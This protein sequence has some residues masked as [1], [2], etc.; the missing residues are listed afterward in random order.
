LLYPLS[1]GGKRLVL[2]RKMAAAEIADHGIMTRNLVAEISESGA[3]F[4]RE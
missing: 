2:S 3:G 4:K 1:Y